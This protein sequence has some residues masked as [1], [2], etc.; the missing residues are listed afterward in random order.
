MKFF[1]IIKKIFSKRRQTSSVSVG[2]YGQKVAP[3]LLA[4]LVSIQS[5]AKETSL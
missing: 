5:L 3:P 4:T 1:M 2:S